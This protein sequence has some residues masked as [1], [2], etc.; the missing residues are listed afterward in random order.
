[1]CCQETGCLAHHDVHGEDPAAR[2]CTAPAPA[3]LALLKGAQIVGSGLW[4][5]TVTPTGAA[6][7]QALNATYAPMPPMRRQPVAVI[8][9]ELL[10]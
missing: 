2:N 9:S 4:G 6:L 3:T 8:G 7:L 10:R 1:M 5:E